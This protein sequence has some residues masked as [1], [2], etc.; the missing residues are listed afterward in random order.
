MKATEQSFRV[1]LLIMLSKV[2]LSVRPVNKNP[3][4]SFLKARIKHYHL[5]EVLFVVSSFPN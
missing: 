5:V 2:D 1:V 3:S 4:V